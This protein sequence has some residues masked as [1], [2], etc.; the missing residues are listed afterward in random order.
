MDHGSRRET[1][2]AA[3]GDP[4]GRD[5][6]TELRGASRRVVVQAIAWAGATVASLTTSQRIAEATQDATPSAEPTTLPFMGETFIGQ[7]SDPDTFVAIVVA[8]TPSGAEDRQARAY[9]CNGADIAEW[10]DQGA[11]TGDGQLELRAPTGAQL[12][13]QLTEDAA[14]GTITLPDGAQ[15]TFETR[16]ATSADGLYTFLITPDGRVAGRSAGGAS[17]EGQLLVA[18]TIT[19][20]NGESSGY[21]WPVKMDDTA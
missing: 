6:G 13:G 2:E 16:P 12:V 10:F 7:T 20:P 9:V 8:E 14:I 15:F 18:G 21:E 17:I 19:L 1:L 4:R 11:V 3:M 5:T